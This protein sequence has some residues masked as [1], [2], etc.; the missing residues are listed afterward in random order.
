MKYSAINFRLGQT[1]LSN[2]YL[3]SYFSMF[4]NRLYIAKML[5]KKQL[6]SIWGP[7]ANET[8]RERD[9]EAITSLYEFNGGFLISHK[10]IYYLWDRAH[11][12][13]R[14][15]G[16]LS[17]LNIPTRFIWGDSDAVSPVE[18]P[19]FLK[20]LLSSAELIFIEGAGHFIMLEQPKKWVELVA[21]TKTG[22][23]DFIP[24]L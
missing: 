1:L 20:Y 17:Q 7:N 13:F 4:A 12:E 9:I 2:V 18:I 10:T 23:G 15:F 11:F 6:T 24:F 8:E 3:G 14:W 19:Q 5:T 16:A 22:W 21:G